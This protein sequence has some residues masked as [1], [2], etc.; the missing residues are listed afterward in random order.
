[1]TNRALDI[2]YLPIYYVTGHR[3]AARALIARRNVHSVE[4]RSPTECTFRRPLRAQT[5]ASHGSDTWPNRGTEALK[6]APHIFKKFDSIFERI[7]VLWGV[8]EP[9][10]AWL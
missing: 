10:I 1:M 4:L 6:V 9:A 8:F 3:I 5:M 2:E 7:L